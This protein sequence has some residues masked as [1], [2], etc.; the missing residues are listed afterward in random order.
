M[1]AIL[2]P[3]RDAISH[4]KVAR[5]SNLPLYFD[6][7]ERRLTFQSVWIGV[8][9]WAVVFLLKT[10]VHWLFHTIVH[11]AEHSPSSF[12]IFVPLFLGAIATAAVTRY[13]ASTLHYH[14][15][16]GQIHELNDIEGDGLER[17]ISLYYSSE[18][19]FERALTGE[20]GVDVRWQLPTFSLAIRKFLATL[21]TLGSGGSGGLEASVTLIGESLSAGLF[22]PRRVVEQADEQIGLVRRLWRW[23]RSSDPDH[24]QT[25]Q[26]SGVAAAV[27]TLLGAPFAAAFFATEVMYRNR[28]IVEKLLYS[29]ISS[30]TAFFLSSLVSGHTALFEVQHLFVPPMELRYYGALIL[31]A[32]VISLVSL[33]FARLRTSFERG[34]HQHQP[35][36]WRRH[37]LG[38]AMTGA[39]ALLVY[40][41]LPLLVERG[42]LPPAAAEHG[43]AL[44]LGPGEGPINAALAG[45]LVGLLGI[46]ALAAKML[47]TLATIGSGGSAGLLVPSIYFGVMVAAAFAPLFNYPPMLLV[48]PAITASLVSIVNVPLAAILLT[49]ELFGAVYMVPAIIVMVVTFIL[50]HQNSIYRTQR[51][52]LS[53][54]H[55]VP[56]YTVRRLL[57]PD[58]WDGRTLLDLD[59][60]KQYQVNVIGLLERHSQAGETAVRR[61]I[62]MDPPVTLPL[63]GGDTLLV[64]GHDEKIEAFDQA[65]QAIVTAEALEQ[66]PEL[67]LPAVEL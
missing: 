60:R 34:F 17:A 20:E 54:M 37:T 53:G 15:S 19:S 67:P 31:V 43:L 66:P 23:W 18:P 12:L 35:N 2:T 9:V 5:L 8:V 32:A 57:I 59:I 26:L 7:E 45:E 62:R 27:S 51:E 48:V 56:G 40:L 13:R 22:K 11:W 25:A 36:I 63:H 46:I 44:I 55:I 33:Y 52:T 65:L 30:L 16:S 49:V 39:I 1:K 4:L 6:Q 10:T 24:L 3:L 21:L 14:D 42:F 38:A 41:G 50:A 58:A 28:P 61:Q 29:L 47:A 64:L